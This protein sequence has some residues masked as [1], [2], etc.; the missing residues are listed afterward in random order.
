M[1]CLLLFALVFDTM[2]QCVTLKLH[3]PSMWYAPFAETLLQP[4]WM[5]TRIPATFLFLLG[6][7]FA[8]VFIV[9][10][11][12]VKYD[13]PRV[14]IIRTP[15]IVIN[16]A[17]GS[18]AL[19]LDVCV[20][21]Q[22]WSMPDLQS[23]V[24]YA[25]TAVSTE[26]A[27]RKAQAGGHLKGQSSKV[28]GVKSTRDDP[29]SA[30]NCFQ[31]PLLPLHGNVH[32]L[33]WFL[34][35]LL[36]VLDVRYLHEYVY[37]CVESNAPNPLEP[38]AGQR[39]MFAGVQEE[40]R[41]RGPL[42]FALA[43]LP[44]AAAWL[45][46]AVQLAR[47]S[48]RCRCCECCIV[49]EDD[50]ATP[51]VNSDLEHVTVAPA[52]GQRREQWEG[53][54]N[55]VGDDFDEGEA[56]ELG[57][58]VMEQQPSQ[59]PQDMGAGIANRDDVWSCA[60]RDDVMRLGNLIDATPALLNLRGGVGVRVLPL[61]QHADGADD[62]SLHH[63]ESMTV[64]SGGGGGARLCAKTNPKCGATALHYAVLGNARG[65]VGSLLTRGANPK[66]RTLSGLCTAE[67]LAA[68]CQYDTMS[69]SVR[70]MLLQ[71]QQEIV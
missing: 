26:K 8:V 71:A 22:D 65:A 7:W 15:H 12:V 9:F 57:A 16:V 61:S 38:A 52:P 34:A 59:Q 50:M 32:W 10:Q 55:V 6:S 1:L 44:A 30:R 28:A 4:H 56:G 53:A 68:L 36:V 20:M 21:L 54:R 39:N 31:L 70:E 13:D 17:L 69:G 11:E 51:A 49:G 33:L 18:A 67:E 29:I 27:A 2:C 42:Y 43:V 45:M 66:L 19:F 46:L 60:F 35:S 64:G 40:G 23:L 48:E 63:S 5:T 3:V 58:S 41:W 24:L 25:P 47:N 14:N 37:W 62:A